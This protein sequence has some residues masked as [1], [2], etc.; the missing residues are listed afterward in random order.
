MEEKKPADD[1]VIPL[2]GGQD[3]TDGSEQPTNGKIEK[4]LETGEGKICYYVVN[5]FP[6]RPTVLFLHGLSANHTTWEKTAGVLKSLKI[7]CLL[8]D[9]RGH[10]HS[11]KKKKK[12]LYTFERFSRDLKLI[13]EKEKIEK[14]IIVGYSF[15]GSLALDFSLRY[16]ERIAGLVLLSAN[17]VNPL[18]YWRL[19]FFIPLAKIGIGLLSYLVIWQK[20]K[21]YSYYRP[22]SSKGYWK[23][24]WLGFK[25]MP[26][27]VNLWMLL[28]M[29]RLDM[30]N[31]LGKIKVPV[32][33]V[34]A[35]RD[36][37]V[38]RAEVKDMMSSLSYAREIISKNH[39]HF[40][41]TAAADEMT[42]V[43]ISFLKEN[44]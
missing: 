14:A 19:P 34:H 5:G 12:F 41:A 44:S 33:I 32:W 18:K 31:K 23:S 22:L 17:H 38:S 24:V 16:P 3:R 10:G 37:F 25:T 9:L 15:G 11:D 27:S 28:M 7:N 42:E 8:P 39:N 36:P 1:P 43:I 30:K 21:K 20:R 29:G 6:G 13:L 2:S 4:R 26:W 40:L 35:S